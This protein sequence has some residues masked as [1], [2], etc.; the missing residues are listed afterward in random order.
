MLLD[1]SGHVGL[2]SDSHADYFP[3][4][5]KLMELGAASA[6]RWH[7]DGSYNNGSPYFYNNAFHF[8]RKSKVE[9]SYSLTQLCHS[10]FAFLL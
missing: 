1:V 4:E 7:P 5:R 2:V 8:S 3:D 9:N 6:N 10:A